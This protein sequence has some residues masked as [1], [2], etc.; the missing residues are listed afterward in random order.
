MKCIDLYRWLL[1]TCLV[2]ASSACSQQQVHLQT[3]YSSNDC[4]LREPTI[5]LIHTPAELTKI[6][7]SK[8]VN[9]SQTTVVLPEVDYDKQSL[10]LYAL[11]QK[12]TAG[13]SIELYRDDAT[14]KEQTLYL[15]VR[16]LQ[17][18]SG[19]MQAQVITSPCQIY[20]LPQADYAEIVV[21]NRLAD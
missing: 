9:F 15:P 8:P 7:Q 17:P 2:I 1:P 3:I 14:I 6:I 19:S 5:R 12:P 20:S 4:A 21:E 18:E 13:Y 16:V 11:G 10:V